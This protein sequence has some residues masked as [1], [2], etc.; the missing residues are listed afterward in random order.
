MDL[1]VNQTKQHGSGRPPPPPPPTPIPA[2]PNIAA[3]SSGMLAKELL[4]RFQWRTAL[5]YLRWARA[6]VPLALVVLGGVAAALGAGLE[7]L[8]FVNSGPALNLG[9]NGRLDV[10]ASESLLVETALIRYGRAEYHGSSTIF[11]ADPSLGRSL[12]GREAGRATRSYSYVS[13]VGVWPDRMNDGSFRERVLLSVGRYVGDEPETLSIREME[14]HLFHV[15]KYPTAAL[16]PVFSLT[17]YE[18]QILLISGSDERQTKTFTSD[19]LG[20][21]P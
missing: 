11:E 12:S 1:P 14:T 16:S 2:S 3:A 15:R 6:L 20:A 8:P 4:R 13:A 17:F 18:D 21:L 9:A 19:L 10:I 7:S 5:R